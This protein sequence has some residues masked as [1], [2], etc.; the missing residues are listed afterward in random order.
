MRDITGEVSTNSQLMFSYGPLHMDIS[1]L[2]D[3]QRLMYI[4]ADTGCSLNDQPGVMD[5]RDRWCKRESVQLDDDDDDEC[6][7]V[8]S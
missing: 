5:D 3:Q 6:R 7:L 4:S 1:V 8:S 2:A